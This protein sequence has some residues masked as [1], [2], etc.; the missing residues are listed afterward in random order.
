MPWPSPEHKERWMTRDFI[1]AYAP[2]LQ[3]T[4][5]DVGGGTQKYRK[6][7]TSS[8]HV[9]DY[10]VLDMTDVQG[11]DFIGDV[12]HMPLADQSFDGANCNQ[13]LE[14]THHPEQVMS[15]IARICRPGGIL[16]F[17]VP[18]IIGAHPCPHD[19]FRFT[20][21]GVEAIASAYFDPVHIITYGGLDQ[22]LI[23]SDIFSDTGEYSYASY[24]K[25]QEKKS[26]SIPTRIRRRI[27]RKIFSLFGTHV[28]IP[29]IYSNI[30][31]VLRRNNQPISKLV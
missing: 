12:H 22:I 3:G 15:E 10:K 19:Y 4:I 14:H 24:M 1:T 28:H 5:L 25:Q 20:V 27:R 9:Q 16:L 11:V 17:T 2:L 26:A 6:I 13:V 18:F 31:C 7:I 21:E 8:P 29:S 30:G 23:S